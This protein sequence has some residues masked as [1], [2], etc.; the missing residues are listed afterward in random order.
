MQKPQNNRKQRTPRLEQA[1]T[2]PSHRSTARWQADVE[3]H[4]EDARPADVDEVPSC[5]RASNRTT[6]T[7]VRQPVAPAVLKEVEDEADS[8][9]EVETDFEPAEEQQEQQERV[10]K[11]TAPTERLEP[12][13]I[14]LA[15]SQLPRR[16]AYDSAMRTIR[17]TPT[18][19]SAYRAL[20]QTQSQGRTTERP[21]Y[22][23]RL[24][25]LS[26]LSRRPV[27]SSA[28]SS[29]WQRINAQ[30]QHW[31]TLVL[32]T[33]GVVVCLLFL[34]RLCL[35]AWTDVH[36]QLNYG[37]PRTM[38]LDA[39]VGDHD[40]AAHPT[41]VIALNLHSQI[42]LFVLPGGN[43]AHAQVLIGP[44]L[45]WANA[46]AATVEA[47]DLNHD[48]KLDLVVQITG[49]P[50]LFGASPAMELVAYATNDGF[51]PLVQV[52]Q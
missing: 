11:A 7:V 46:D 35:L 17:T 8:D 24:L 16:Q 6:T 29:L 44:R 43:A 20:S 18:A 26:R 10:V 52:E 23:P 12:A 9:I 39:V 38:Q 47:H 32:V 30:R 25:H 42:E 37:M 3:E 19:P 14:L 28:G 21:P 15:A 5:T 33:I 40:S 41:H 22:T 36:D 48:G 34:S 2:P 13:P 4:T 1:L 45:L 51:K 31:S 27:A 49:A 50:Q